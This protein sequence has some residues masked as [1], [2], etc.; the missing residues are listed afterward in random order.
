MP[1]V[2]TRDLIVSRDMTIHNLDYMNDIY[3]FHIYILIIYYIMQIYIPRCGLRA[4][5]SLSLQLMKWASRARLATE[6]H[7]A[8]SFPTLQ[9][10]Y[11]R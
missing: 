4:E 6:L 10:A 2:Y 7:R 3:I 9:A 1:T 8:G 5:P 11:H